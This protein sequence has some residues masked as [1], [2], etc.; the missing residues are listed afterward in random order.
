MATTVVT[1]ATT[2]PRGQAQRGFTLIEVVMSMAILTIGLVSL[3]GVFGLAIS[4]TQESQQDMIAKQLANEALESI[5][6]ARD[7][8][9]KQWSD[10][11]NAGDGGIFLNGYQPMYKAGADGILGTADD[12]LSGGYITIQQPGPDGIYG[13]SDD[14]Q[15]SLSNYQRQVQ[16]QPV[17][18]A[19]GNVVA[20]LRA[21]NISIQYYVPRSRQAKTY[22]LT[23]YISQ[24]R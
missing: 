1:Q 13:T 17:T 5:I 23:S 2:F 20:S 9:Q 6:T 24:F 16:I 19:A 7:T 22:T 10:I 8:A 12:A 14:T 18:D 3:L 15:L 4:A 21:I 11:Q